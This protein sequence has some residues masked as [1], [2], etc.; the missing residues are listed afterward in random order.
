[1]SMLAHILSLMAKA[2][3]MPIL[4][5]H[6][7]HSPISSLLC[8][9]EERLLAPFTPCLRK[10][11]RMSHLD[12]KQTMLFSYDFAICSVAVGSLK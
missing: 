2:N 11:D 7:A 3:L 12:D 8:F 9:V 10:G 5:I 6:F 1:M 4:A